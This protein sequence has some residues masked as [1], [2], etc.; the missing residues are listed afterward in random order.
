ML[1]ITAVALGIGISSAAD[2]KVQTGFHYDWWDDTKDNKARQAY[3]P[4]RIEG[5]H[6]EFSLSVLTAHA[7]TNFNPA[8]GESRS[9]SHLLDTKVNLSYEILGK[10]PVDVLIGLD[11]N[12]P[13]GKTDLKQKDLD[14]IMDPDLISINSFGEGF[15]INPTLTVTKEWRNWVAGIGCGYIWRGKY[16]FSSDID[17]KNYDPGDIFNATALIRYY[18][19]SDWHTRFFASYVWYDKDKVNSRDF[20]QEGDFLL[21][22][23]GFHYDQTKW[24]ADFTL[25]S[26]LRS[27]SKFQEEAGR[28]FTEDK[29]NHG[30]EWIGDLSLRY[31][32][33]HKT[34]LK[35]SLQGLW[36]TKNDYPLDSSF[37]VGRREKFSLGL[38]A[39]RIIS[40]NIEGELNVKGFVMHDGEARLPEFRSER[41]YRGLSAG[42]QLTSRF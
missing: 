17:M 5:R 12:L 3:I 41:N 34:T 22:G 18:F 29:N 21:L 24:D 42:I 27:K 28:L 7:Y 11:F 30:D 40:P 1:A 33:N 26:I 32:L 20:Y 37:F 15:N 4:I 10:L 25:R 19:S 8:T 23:L 13:T 2:F 14:L 36:I 6:Q 9:L 31:F 35:S 16:D 38:G 39:T